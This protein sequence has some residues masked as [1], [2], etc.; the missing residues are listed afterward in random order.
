MTPG[1]IRRTG[2]LALRQR[3]LRLGLAPLDCTSSRRSPVMRALP[4]LAE[5]ITGYECDSSSKRPGASVVLAARPPTPWPL[6]AAGVVDGQPTVHHALENALKSVRFPQ[7][8]QAPVLGLV[9][10]A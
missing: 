8:A 7:R 3:R 2:E 1:T 6:H 5:V 4:R 9:S 10:G